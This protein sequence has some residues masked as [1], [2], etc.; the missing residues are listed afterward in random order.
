MEPKKEI[1]FW[2]LFWENVRN[3]GRKKKMR[4]REKEESQREREESEKREKE[5]EVRG[6]K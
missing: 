3:G 5:K 1:L 2:Y 6:E 4:E